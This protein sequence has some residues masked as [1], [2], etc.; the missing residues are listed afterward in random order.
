MWHLD[1]LPFAIHWPKVEWNCPAVLW[2]F[3]GER[4]S[5]RKTGIWNGLPMQCDVGAGSDEQITSTIMS[6]RVATIKTLWIVKSA[7]NAACSQCLQ[8][9]KV[10][11]QDLNSSTCQ[12]HALNYYRYSPGCSCKN[13]ASRFV[14]FHE[15]SLDF[16][17]FLYIS[18]GDKLSQGL[19]A[20]SD[21]HTAENEQGCK[22]LAV[23]AFHISRG[24][25][26]KPD[27]K[28]S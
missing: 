23:W 2:P 11:H 12:H 22:V 24:P 14:C 18:K 6:A 7:K 15:L 20:L 8:R 25:N 26:Q 4:G 3:L 13:E 10:P 19:E 17:S 16:N 9:L 27:L 1:K 28:T 5:V 21:L